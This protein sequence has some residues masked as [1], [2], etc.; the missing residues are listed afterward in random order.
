MSNW[1]KENVSQHAQYFLGD[2]VFADRAIAT[3]VHIL[4]ADFMV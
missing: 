1:Q 4:D 3:E 2:L